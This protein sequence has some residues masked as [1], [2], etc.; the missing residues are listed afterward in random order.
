M[1]LSRAAFASAKDGISPEATRHCMIKSER[2]EGSFMLM[3]AV[4]TDTFI[5]SEIALHGQ[6]QPLPRRHRSNTAHK[7]VA[8]R[9]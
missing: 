7:K 8:A 2:A 6:L 5:S 1:T 9:V 3:M 4:L